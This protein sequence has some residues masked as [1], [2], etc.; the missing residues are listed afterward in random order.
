[1][2]VNP[3]SSQPFI[4]PATQSTSASST[5]NNSKPEVKAE[6][7][8]QGHSSEKSRPMMSLSSGQRLLEQASNRYD[9]MTGGMGW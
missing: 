8:T 4:P 3:G 1:M 7:K 6:S 5:S 9:K 2:K